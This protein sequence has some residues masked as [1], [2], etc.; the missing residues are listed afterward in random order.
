[1]WHWYVARPNEIF[2]DA[3]KWDKCKNHV[4]ERLQGA[5]EC[6]KLDV[7]N[8]HLFPSNTS[9]HMHMVIELN[10]EI[11][12]IDKAVWA[13]LFHSDIYR[14]CA[15]IM[16]IHHEHY[17]PDILISKMELHRVADSRCLCKAKHSYKI[18]DKC[19]SANYLRGKYRTYGFF[20]KPSKNPCK[21][22]P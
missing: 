15:T 18:M 22:L 13:V 12:D 4:R 1:M 21:F 10:E 20:G 2:I 7:K 6:G 19:L 17:S 16:R 9:G 3:D 11:S 8:V 5:I 14:A